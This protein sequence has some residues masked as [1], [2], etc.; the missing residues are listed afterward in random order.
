MTWRTGTK[1]PHTLYEN[2]EPIGM[3]IEP[4]DGQR[5][6]AAMNGADI[7]ASTL[8]ARELSEAFARYVVAD[9]RRAGDDGC[10]WTLEQFLS[11]AEGVPAEVAELA[12][13]EGK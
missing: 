12:R 3:V 10:A 5:I 2:D 4:R 6:A 7:E 1:N 9:W 8:K 13:R 11:N